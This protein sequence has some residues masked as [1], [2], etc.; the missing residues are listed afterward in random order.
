MAP[1]RL[2]AVLVLEKPVQW[3]GVVAR[4]SIRADY[5]SADR[6]SIDHGQLNRYRDT[7]YASESHRE[8]VSPSGQTR[9]VAQVEAIG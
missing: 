4:N 1:E 8:G 7:R 5:A 3:A 2:Q 6:K 9:R